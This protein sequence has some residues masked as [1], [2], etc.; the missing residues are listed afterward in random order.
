MAVTMTT[1]EGHM[2]HPGR[3]DAMASGTSWG[4]ILAGAAGAA[5]LSLILVVLGLG[6][7]FS[8]VSP[9]TATSSTASL[10]GVAAIIWLIA[11][12]IVASAVGGYLAG[13]LRVRWAIDVDEVWFRDTAHG[14]LA[15]AIAAL[16]TAVSLVSIIG[17]LVGAAAQVGADAMKGTAGAVSAA[18]APAAM[19]AAQGS[20]DEGGPLAYFVD[21]LFRSDAAPVVPPTDAQMRAEVVRIFAADLRA[22]QISPG[23]VS[24][25]G[26][27]VARQTGATPAEAERRAADTFAQTKKAINDA[28]AAARQ[29]ADEARR[30]AAYAALWMFVAL[31]SGA[32]SASVAALYG[33]RRRDAVV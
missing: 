11:T 13:R 6:F 14:F 25:V 19:P 17:S 1:G 31:L 4:A 16:V 10:L 26:R 27:I 5:A 12:Q 30:A 22:G 18:A 3:D 20:S 33:G 9:W 2:R 15:W 21:V 8:S 32:F 24:Y 28:A 23:D 7:G 29:A